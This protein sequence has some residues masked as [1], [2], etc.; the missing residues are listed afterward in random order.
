MNGLAGR[1]ILLTREGEDC[2]AWAAELERLGAVPVR[3]P[4]IECR[5][6]DTPAL[7]GRLAAELPR[8]RWLAFTS[9]RGVAAFATLRKGGGT[10][11]APGPIPAPAAVPAEV[12]VAVVGPA[13]AQA[14]AKT[15]GRTDLDG[16]PGGTAASLG[17]ALAPMLAPRDRVLIAVAENA[18][19]TLE[20]AI[21]SAGAD[22]ARLDVY[23]TVPSPPAARKAASSTLGADNVFLASPSAVS[24]FVNRVR[25][26]SAPGIFTIGPTTTAAAR[27]AGLEVTGEA[28]RPGLDGLVEAMRCAS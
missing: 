2:A 28:A 22:C 15:L 10:G 12:K 7:R 1:R 9:R 25:L 21:A 23:R 4:C 6:I 17:A 14:A 3:F 20:A 24:G 16:G 18:G 11:P 26:D 8:A 19:R 13:T 27:A 5:E